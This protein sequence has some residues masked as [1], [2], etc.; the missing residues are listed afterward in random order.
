MGFARFAE[1]GSR[2]RSPTCFTAF[3]TPMPPGEASTVGETDK[4]DAVAY[5]LKQ[6]GFPEGRAELTSDGDTLATIQITGKGGPIPVRTGTLVRTTGCLELHDDR[7]WELTNATEPERT[8]R[9]RFK[10]QE[11]SRFATI[12]RTDDRPAESVS[13]SDRPSR[14]PSRSDGVSGATR[15][16]RCCQRGLAGNAR[17]V[18]HAVTDDEHPM[19]LSVVAKRFQ[20]VNLAPT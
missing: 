2:G 16:R 14:S 20:K 5:L 17:A 1:H 19:E 15:R 6:N 4:L 10:D 3:A 18:V 12:R 8:A 7:E 11:P 13:E 9:Y